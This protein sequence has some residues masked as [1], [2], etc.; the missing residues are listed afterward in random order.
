MTTTNDTL[1]VWQRPIPAGRPGA[2]PLAPEDVAAAGVAL[3]DREGLHTVS[4]KRVASKLNVPLTR[5]EGYLRSREDLLDLMLDAALGEIELGP[6]DPDV[7]WRT[8][9][10][11]IAHAT[12]G[13]ALRHP[14]LRSLAGT[15]TPC[16]P[17]GLRHTE[18][19]LEAVDGL[20]L[21]AATATHAVN[22]VLAFVY[23]FVQLEMGVSGR[24]DDATI[25]R[26]TA[27]AHYLMDA[28]A[29]GSYPAL[30]RVFTDA[31]ISTDDAFETGLSYVLDGVG[32]QIERAAGA[33][34]TES[35]D[36]ADPR[37][38][39]RRSRRR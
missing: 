11:T 35:A 2:A 30:A 38:P 6:R 26:R 33:T 14:W 5:L 39:A 32:A 34:S 17:R 4:V 8:D 3:A 15:R 25:E 28:I 12:Q 21:D 18:R 36:S 19:V 31:S 20:D 23:G 13:A 27:T 7:D 37:T 24:K 29:G 22:T 10:T 1:L 9:L 16:G